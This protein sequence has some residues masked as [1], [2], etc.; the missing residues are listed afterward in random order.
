MMLTLCDSCD[1]CDSCDLETRN[2]MLTSCDRYDHEVCKRA[3]YYKL[4][5]KIYSNEMTLTGPSYNLYKEADQGG[6]LGQMILHLF[7]T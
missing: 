4:T 6:P 2:I 3:N 1:S 5:R 7:M